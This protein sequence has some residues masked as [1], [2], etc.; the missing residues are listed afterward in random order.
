MND[1]VWWESIARDGAAR[2]GRLQTPHGPV[3]TPGF[4]PV[5]TR[6]TVKT[7]DA[8]DLRTVGAQMILANTYH[9][10][11]RP[12][13]ETVAALGELARVHGVGRSDPHR[14]GRVPGVLPA[15]PQ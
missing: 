11:L 6:G 9:L 7:V 2:L 14:L 3:D 15:H 13:A 12:G 1:P 5:G 4:M 10:M 8:A